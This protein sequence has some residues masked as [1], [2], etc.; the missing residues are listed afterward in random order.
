MFWQVYEFNDLK[1]GIYTLSEVFWTMKSWFYCSFNPF[2]NSNDG[3]SWVLCEFRSGRLLVCF[4]CIY[5]EVDW[6]KNNLGNKN[7]E[8]LYLR[9]LYLFSLSNKKIFS[10]FI[11]TSDYHAHPACRTE[12]ALYTFSSI[13]P[14]HTSPNL[15]DNMAVKIIFHQVHTVRWIGESG[16][17]KA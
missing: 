17:Y 5:S 3:F 9:V 4:K 13:V 1:N 8:H 7:K 6:N 10:T 12:T 2:I 15:T 16:F 11:F 14:L